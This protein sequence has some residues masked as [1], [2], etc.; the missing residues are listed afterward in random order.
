MDLLGQQV[1]HTKF[2]S[3]RIKGQEGN[4]ITV[5]FDS[6]GAHTFLYPQS[7]EKHLSA[8]DPELACKIKE[9]LNKEWEEQGNRELALRRKVEK[10]AEQAKAQRLAERKTGKRLPVGSNGKM[11]GKASKQSTV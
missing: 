5:Y 6:Y 7:F 2:G 10:L 1:M 4:T 3:G 8:S 11:K 9:D